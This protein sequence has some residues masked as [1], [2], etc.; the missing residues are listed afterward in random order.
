MNGA[1]A[2]VHSFEY[3]KR[4]GKSEKLKRIWVQF[5]NKATGSL[6]REDMKRE[7]VTN[8]ENPVAV[9]IS[10][11]K[12]T[13]EIPR[14]KIKVTRYQFPMVLCFCMTSYKS[15]GQTLQSAILDFKDA[16][17][18]HG[19]FYVGATRV[20]TSEGL[21]V[22]NFSTSQITCRED[23]KKELKILRNNRKYTFSKTYL[24]TKIWKNETEYKIAYLNINGFYH[25]MKNFDKDLNLSNLSFICIAET[26]LL[27]SIQ[28][29]N[30]NRQLENFEII[31]R[32]DV[33]TADNVAHMGM[34]LL[35]NKWMDIPDAEI[36]FSIVSLASAKIQYGKLTIL[37][38]FTTLFV[39]VNKTPSSLETGDIANKLKNEDA[40]FILG[41]FNINPHKE[42]GL[43]KIHELSNTLEMQQ[44]NRESTRNNNTLDLVFRKHV[45]ELDFMP[46]IF[47]NFYSDHSTVGFRYCKD[48]TIS[49][50]Y[51]D[52]QIR[53]QDK[54]FLKKGTIDQMTKES[55]TIK[56]ENMKPKMGTGKE[57]KESKKTKANKKQKKHHDDTLFRENDADTIIMECPLDTARLS[58]IKK[59]LL[60]EWVDSHVINCYLFLISNQYSNIY[61]VD[62]WFN[63]DFKIKKFEMIDRRFKNDNLFNHDIW[64]IPINCSNRHWFLITIDVTHIRDNKIKLKIYDSLGNLELWK[65]NLEEAKIKDFILWKFKKTFNLQEAQLV[66]ITTDLSLEIPQQNNYID[67]GVFALMYA[68]YLAA[69]KCFSFGPDMRKFRRKIYDEIKAE[70][71]ENIIWDDE[72]D[73]ELPANFTENISRPR[74]M[75]KPRLYKSEENL[76]CGKQNKS[77]KR[78]FNDEVTTNENQREKRR[79]SAPNLYTSQFI[80]EESLKIYKFENPG[81]NLCFSNA[82]TSVIL[83]IK[84]FQDLLEGN[85]PRLNQNSVCSELKKLS[86]LPNNTNSS[87][88]NLRREIQE[89]CIE[90]QQNTKTFD[91]DRQHDAAEFLN[92]LL[93]HMFYTEIELVNRLF[94]QTQER[95]FCMNGRCNIA[96]LSPSNMVNIVAIPIVGTTLHMC[97]DEYF[98]QHQ[99][100]RNCPHCDSQTASQV[101][102]FTVEPCVLIVQ[103]NRFNYSNKH[104]RTMKMH[105]QIDVAMEIQLPTGSLY[106]IVGAI[107]HSGQTTSSGHYTA[108]IYCRERNS[109]YYC[110]DERISEIDS[111]LEEEYSSTIYLVIYERK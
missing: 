57:Y 3:D 5:P 84:G 88:K 58:N 97:L 103:L 44:I 93:E 63:D 46:F 52:H 104:K 18:K 8:E 66:F 56:D 15:Q 73:L 22:R 36:K 71:L 80:V 77:Q 47:E 29:E 7:G 64:L 89:K 27:S 75:G 49:N 62:S 48:G 100:Q 43:R 92:S 96:D 38:G 31:G 28:D 17:S 70:K 95:I 83:N 91:D 72:E 110:N 87:T 2:F 12:L 25:N 55:E 105:D 34:I 67:C 60:G 61:A 24:G 39:Y 74:T 82:V 21:F 90:H 86:Q 20:R 101:T 42:D 33:Y 54:Q 9:P 13:F 10:E 32:E 11:I 1:R 23:V 16:V 78:N 59:L 76:D 79:K 19:T 45:N 6:L 51:K 37:D 111:L 94:G 40:T 85:N 81:T 65:K 106:E 41:D 4:K 53:I 26:K 14:I 98:N 50:E 109:F 108:A 35:K 102:E 68:K 99:I 30:I 107:F 69:E